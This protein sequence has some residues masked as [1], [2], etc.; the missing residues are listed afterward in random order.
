MNQLMHRVVTDGTGK[1]AALEFT[2]VVGKTG[3]STG[4]RDIWFVG[5][6][7]KYVTSVWF[8]NDDNRPMANGTTGGGVA[9][10]L[11]H[12]LMASAHGTSRIG[13]I[14]GLPVHPVQAAERLQLAAEP[15]RDQTAGAGPGAP[16]RQQSIMPS[17]TREALRKLAQMMREAGGLPADSAPAPS[18]QGSRQPLG[19]ERRVEVPGGSPVTLTPLSARR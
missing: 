10:H 4:P 13:S 16:R 8:G 1:A 11:Y 15:R 5:G 6:T 19:P 12:S 7:G 2:H 18:Q 9:A 14:P 3:T 17:E